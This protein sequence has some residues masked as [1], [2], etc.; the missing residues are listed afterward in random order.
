MR[1]R[2]TVLRLALSALAAA[3]FVHAAGFPS[4][5]QWREHHFGLNSTTSVEASTNADPDGDGVPNL[6]EYALGGDPLSANSAPALSV[7][8]SGGVLHASFA[9]AADDLAY[10]VQSSN[11]LTQWTELARDP[12][13]VGAAAQVDA[14]IDGNRKFLR[15]EVVPLSVRHTP[16]PSLKVATLGDSKTQYAGFVQ[17]LATE[18]NPLSRVELQADG[19]IVWARRGGRFRHV[20]VPDREATAANLVPAYGDALAADPF[21]RG[22]N[23][24]FAGDTATGVLKRVD[25]V[26]ATGAQIVVYAAG[27]NVGTTDSS[28]AATT[29]AIGEAVDRIIAAG[30]TCIVCTIDP[31]AT[32]ASNPT[33][34]Q[35]TPA[36]M[37]RILD[38][39]TWIRSELPAR[40]AI[41][42]DTFADL[43]DPDNPVYGNAL[44]LTLR[45]GVHFAPRGAFLAG[46]RLRGI[47]EQI[48]APGTWFDPDPSKNNL[49]PNGALAGTAGVVGGSC[50]GQAPTGWSI[51]NTT[52]GENNPVTAASSLA[53]GSEP[54]SQLWMVDITSAGGGS[55]TSN[56]QTIRLYPTAVNVASAGLAPT[57]WVSWFVEYEVSSSEIAGSLQATLTAA[58]ATAKDLGN[59]INNRATEPWPTRAY[60]GWFETT[61]VPVGTATTLVP[62]VDLD[63]RI[64]VPGSMQVRIKRALLRVVENPDD[65]F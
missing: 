44:P 21:F 16:S 12:G 56:T 49:I 20:L 13:E 5:V 10:V 15:L 38:I 57:Q 32:V 51:L 47:L 4:L 9:R 43:V 55:S 31:R 50:T 53:P 7:E 64:D 2:P 8:T 39:N 54:G 24:G 41:V 18:G 62:R 60:G 30:R 27:T 58:P 23:F 26:L 61:P 52:P 46:E 22:A 11:D 25:A 35:L 42:A 37:Q 14:P 36:H 48:I 29:A 6:L 1:H 40:G 33:G 59:T 19:P 28:V 34:Y 17:F 65:L 3:S 63:I 45:D